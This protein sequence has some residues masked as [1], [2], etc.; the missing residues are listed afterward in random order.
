[1][2]DFDNGRSAFECD[3]P[4]IKAAWNLSPPG[5]TRPWGLKRQ[6][7]V[8]LRENRS[9]HFPFT[10]PV[11]GR[12]GQKPQTIRKAKHRRCLPRQ[13]GTGRLRS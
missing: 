7:D 13:N 11:S 10:G 1:M 3:C 2:S 8:S 6:S 9:R 5:P 12:L 4:G